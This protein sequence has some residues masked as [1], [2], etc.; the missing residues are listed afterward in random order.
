MG[1]WNAASRETATER[2]KGTP[3][4]LPVLRLAPDEPI[5]GVGVGLL[6]EGQHGEGAG[7]E[8][9]GALGLAAGAAALLRHGVHQ[10]GDDVGV[11]GGG[12]AGP[13]VE[14]EVDP[15]QVDVGQTWAVITLWRG[16]LSLH[17]DPSAGGK[18]VVEEE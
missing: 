8:E 5:E 17:S 4:G 7:G 13:D 14:Q 12:V 18:L 16:F 11:V 6:L 3:S 9:G 1:A 10:G 2:R 15:D